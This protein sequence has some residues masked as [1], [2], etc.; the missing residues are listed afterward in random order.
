MG[1][2]LAVDMGGTFI[3]YSLFDEAYSLL[4]EG[5][6]SS[7]Q[8]PLDFLNQLFDIV[9]Q[10][11]HTLDG[12]ALCMAGTIHPET[13]VNDD[14]SVGPRFK[15][16]N[17][18]RELEMRYHIPV[19]LENDSN[20][21]ALGEMIQGAG[22]GYDNFCMITFGTGIGAA[23]VIDRKL[24]R[25]KH[26]R[27]GEVGITSVG[28]TR[29]GDNFVIQEA[30][31]TAALA[32]KVSEM[33]GREVNGK[34]ILDHLEDGKIAEIYKEWIYKSAIVVG[35]MAVTI[36]PESVLIGG[37]ISENQRFI[38]DIRQCVYKLYPHLE[39]YTQIK[40]CEQGNMAGR[41]GALYL[42]L[43]S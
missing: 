2:Y 38:Q 15:E 19:L 23:I 33:L 27:A 21:A 14:F 37:G 1:K 13:G 31:A 5:S 11:H 17:F 6:V 28:I 18:K 26:F 24:Y 3:K 7:K 25:G 4:E 40:A 8:N 34:Y 41:I 30:G 32:K 39:Q 10:Y 20:C 35:N 36:D 42:L 12:I 16:H 29:E 22:R 43:Q 9:D